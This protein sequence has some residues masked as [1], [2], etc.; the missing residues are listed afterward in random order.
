MKLYKIIAVGSFRA[1]RPDPI[2]EPVISGQ[3]IAGFYTARAVEANNPNQA[4]AVIESLIADELQELLGVTN[5]IYSLSIESCTEI[6][7]APDFVSS[8]FTFFEQD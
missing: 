1:K 3:P 5:E 2:P 8:G 7:S 4:F 6:F